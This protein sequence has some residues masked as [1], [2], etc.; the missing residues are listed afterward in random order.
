VDISGGSVLNNMPLTS[1]FLPRARVDEIFSEATRCKLVYVIAGAG[2]GK[3]QAV[4]HYLQ[5]QSD[6]VIRWIQLSESDNIVA[7]YWERLT[8]NISMDNPDYAQSLRELGFP[9]TV[10]RFKKFVELAKNMEHRSHKTFLVLDDFHLISSPEAL[11]FAQRCANLQLPGAC[12]IIISRKEPE[13]NTVAM[14]SKGDASI[15]TEDDLRF[16]KDEINAFLK[17]RDIRISVKDVPKIEES[18]KGWALAVKMFSL[19]LKRSP[20][21]LSRA[22]DAT[23]QNIFK[24]LETE[25]FNDLPEEAQRRLIQLSLTP[26][27]PLAQLNETYHNDFFTPYVPLLAPFVWFDSFIS[28]YRIHPLFLE[29]LQ[30]KQHILSDKEKHDIY[31]RVT[32]WC[33]ENEFYT[34]AVKFCALS[35][36]YDRM[37]EVLLSYPFKMPR[38][39]CEYFLKIIND[40]DPKDE[41]D[42]DISVLTL[43]VLFV[44]LLLIGMGNYEEAG[45]YAFSTIKNWENIGT[46]LAYYLLSLAYSNLTYIGIYTSTVTYKYDSPDFL[47]KSLEYLKL[48]SVPTGGGAATQTGGGVETGTGAETGGGTGK[49]KSAFL[50]ADVR[51]F[52]CTVGDDA[53]YSDFDKFLERSRETAVYVE[54]TSHGMYRGYDDLVACEIAYFKNQPELV[55][56]YAYSAII[57]ALEK[58]QYSIASMANGYLLRLSVHEGDYSL[59]KEIIKQLE[60]FPDDQVFWNRQLLYDLFTGFFFAQIG[61]PEFVASWLVMDEN[62]VELDVH[63]P[64]RELIVGAKYYIASRKYKQALTVLYNSYP[65]EPLHRF[66]L[67]ELTLTLLLSLVRLKTGDTEGAVKDFEK[68]YKLS[69]DGVFEMSFVELGKDFRSLAVAASEYKQCSV[70]KEWISSINRKASAY[71]KKAA[72]VSSSFLR[73]NKMMVD[74]PLSQRERDILSD[75]YHGLSR[76][77][78]AATRYLS[79][80][81]INKILQSIFIKLDANNNIDVIRIAIER[82]LLD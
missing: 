24:L 75:L 20:N 32:Q 46:G 65:R 1:H 14:F 27:L 62:E 11:E 33:F 71:A 31:M 72:V 18:T 35:Q 12:V 48:S 58:G 79:V 8:H 70:P 63:I 34:D 52:A 78:M 39:S 59:S 19:V 5:Q 25:A 22:I 76:D 29:F 60:S 45:E 80:N 17:Q 38:N 49:G 36:Q 82:K 54:Q 10:A 68:A 28:D 61:L 67:G 3:T 44:P 37:L 50:V 16:N 77:E 74:I 7:H 55:R 13:I 15:V 42:S 53:D 47:K 30:S 73:E 9:D 56:K 4:H 2:Y 66:R 57:K 23:R 21:D 26:E 43:K 64:V 40:I 51:S 6:A 81:T 41:E 69:Y